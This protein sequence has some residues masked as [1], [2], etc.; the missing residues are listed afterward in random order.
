MKLIRRACKACAG[1]GVVNEV[2]PESARQERLAAGLTLRQMADRM[3]IHAS[4]L[5]DME[6]GKRPFIQ[7]QIEAFEKAIRG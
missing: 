7:K 6:R 1:T 2:F 5:H 4:Y 3:S